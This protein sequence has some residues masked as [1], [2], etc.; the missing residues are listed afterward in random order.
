MDA[1]I[2]SLGNVTVVT[3]TSKFLDASNAPDLKKQ[4]TTLLEHSPRLVLDLGRID[5]VDSSGCGAILTCLRQVNTVAGK[6]AV[7]GVTPPVRALFDLVRMNRILEIH[8]SR[9]AAVRAIGG[10]V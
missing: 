5:F 10:E 2:E 8:D 7:C 1:T 4:V 9:E 6:M 3:L